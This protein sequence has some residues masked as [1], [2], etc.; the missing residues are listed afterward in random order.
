MRL[1]QKRTET[2]HN[3]QNIA[4]GLL[5]DFFPWKVLIES[6][7]SRSASVY[8]RSVSTQLFSKI[9]QLKNKLNRKSSSQSLK[10]KNPLKSE[11]SFIKF[12]PKVGK[13]SLS[14]MVGLYFVSNQWFCYK[15]WKPEAQKLHLIPVEFREI[16][17]VPI[18]QT[19]HI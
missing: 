2:K 17:Y 19:N 5:L 3:N 13:L 10:W 15:I 14:I 1:T 18:S 9:L 4:K 8:L 11:A 7:L 16:N 6:Q 12:Q